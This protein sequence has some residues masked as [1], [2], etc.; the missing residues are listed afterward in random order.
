MRPILDPADAIAAPEVRLRGR[1]LSSVPDE[2]YVA[3]HHRDGASLMIEV[4]AFLDVKVQMRPQ[5]VARVSDRGDPLAELHALS[6]AHLRASL[7]E[8]RQHGVAMVADLEEDVIAIRGRQPGLANGLV[9]VDVAD[10]YHRA[11]CRGQHGLAEPVPGL[12]PLRIAFVAAPVDE[13]HEVEGVP[14]KR[15]G[16]MVTEERAAPASIAHSPANGGAVGTR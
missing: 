10:A 16:V 12:R 6:F 5:R 2:E 14:H 3:E 13:P 8:V 9:R 4:R 15:S 11:I 7:L 1:R